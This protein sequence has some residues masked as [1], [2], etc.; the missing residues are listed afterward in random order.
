[1]ENGD[2]KPEMAKPSSGYELKTIKWLLIIN[3]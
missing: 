3:R 2:W 1:M